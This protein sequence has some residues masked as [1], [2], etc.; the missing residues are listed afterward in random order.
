MID[1]GGNMREHID[2]NSDYFFQL[3]PA[4]EYIHII[5]TGKA[6]S[7]NL[8]ELFFEISRLDRT[9]GRN[10]ILCEIKMNAL[11]SIKDLFVLRESI[12]KCDLHPDARMAII[13]RHNHWIFEQLGIEF[14]QMSGSW[15]RIFENLEEACNW[16][17]DSRL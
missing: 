7:W 1:G 9:D 13:Y 2:N 15:T 12:L 17:S 6:D 3:V 4:A 16:L 14:F 8:E 11:E 5:A 10:R